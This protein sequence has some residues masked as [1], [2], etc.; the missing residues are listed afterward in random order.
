MSSSNTEDTSAH[1]VPQIVVST[2]AETARKAESAS[3]LGTAAAT[4]HEPRLRDSSNLAAPALGETSIMP[5]LRADYE[6]RA[7]SEAVICQEPEKFKAG[8]E[9]FPEVGWAVNKS[10]SGSKEHKKG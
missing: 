7:A 6:G 9:E 2:P 8:I 1:L 4:R 3:N 10:T 5:P